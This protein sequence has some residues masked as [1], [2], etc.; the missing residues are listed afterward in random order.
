MHGV[1]D[2]DGDAFCIYMCAVV[3]LLAGSFVIMLLCVILTLSIV[4]QL[5]LLNSTRTSASSL[6]E[7][8]TRKAKRKEILEAFIALKLKSRAQVLTLVELGKEVI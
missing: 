7:R 1:D 6:L 8:Q 5:V 4:Y 2:D 3:K